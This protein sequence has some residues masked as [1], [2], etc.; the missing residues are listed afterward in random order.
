M[1]NEKFARA[2]KIRDRKRRFR[3]IWELSKAKLV[4][5][6]GEE[7]NAEEEDEGFGN[8][9]A[10]LGLKKKASHGKIKGVCTSN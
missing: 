6:G 8:D 10:R 5:E 4:C 1:S 9:A 7:M 3:A 2:Q